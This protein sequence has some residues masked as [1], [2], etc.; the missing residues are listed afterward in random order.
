MRGAEINISLDRPEHSNIAM[1]DQQIWDK[2]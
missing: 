1:S 2:D